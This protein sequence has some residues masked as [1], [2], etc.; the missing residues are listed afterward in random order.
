MPTKCGNIDLVPRARTYSLWQIKLS[1][2]KNH[3]Q[4]KIGTLFLIFVLLDS[5]SLEP[6]TH[7]VRLVPRI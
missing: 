3:R 7:C 6:D 4:A 1:F 5:I 2:D